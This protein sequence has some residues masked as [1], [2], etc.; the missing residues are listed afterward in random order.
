LVLSHDISLLSFAERLVV[1]SKLAELD[2]LSK[3]VGINPKDTESYLPK[4]APAYERYAASLASS[5]QE[6]GSDDSE[7]I[8]ERNVGVKSMRSA[9]D[10][11]QLSNK[12]VL[13]C[14]V[15]ALWSVLHDAFS[16]NYN[17]DISYV[18]DSAVIAHAERSHGGR[19]AAT[20]APNRPVEL[21]NPADAIRYPASP[22]NPVDAF[23]S[24]S[25]VRR[26]PPVHAVALLPETKKNI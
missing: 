5:W 23:P 4:I 8:I 10:A 18:R 9:V 13:Y 22:R 25:A 24:P 15:P 17:V 12:L 11:V 14:R 2:V 1:E 20:S 26:P 21:R 16:K 3:S 7:V 19:P 6:E